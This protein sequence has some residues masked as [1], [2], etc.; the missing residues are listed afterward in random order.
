MSVGQAWWRGATEALRL[1]RLMALMTLV[2]LALGLVA[3][4]RFF[5]ELQSELGASAAPLDADLLDELQWR[6][7]R[8]RTVDSIGVAHA[9]PAILLEAAETGISGKW[10]QA[11]RSLWLLGV[12]YFLLNTFFVAGLLDVAARGKRERLLPEFFAGGAR[13]FFRFLRLNAGWALAAATL[14][15]FLGTERIGGKG[16]LGDHPSERLALALP[17]GY[18]LGLAGF[19]ALLRL[20]V[21]YTQVALA[22]EPGAGVGQA[23]AGAAR[24]LARQGRGA[25]GLYIALAVPWLLGLAG[26]VF[27][28]ALLEPESALLLVLGFLLQEG[29]IFYRIGVRSAF[30]CAELA[31]FR[32][33]QGR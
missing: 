18:A 8:F 28:D 2:N 25:I 7:G 20:V 27:A 4:L 5:E 14:L 31:F 3:G 33:R 16:I 6:G 19:L 30:L 23:L 12:L 21:D 10:L 1:W 29:F 15:A 11:S 24:F 32:A 22:A 13:N 9:A 26:F 17:L